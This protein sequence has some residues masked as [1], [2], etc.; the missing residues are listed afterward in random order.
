MI[1]I[2]TTRKPTQ[3]IR[4][5]IKELARVIPGSIRLTRGKQGFA[6]FCDAAYEQGATRLLLVGGFHGNPGRIGFLQYTGDAW[7]FFPPTIIIKSTQLLR[8]GQH[9]P[10]R[11][12]KKVVVLP[13][14]SFDLNKAK[15][16]AEA[17]KV[18]CIQRA[19]LPNLQ[20]NT[21]VLR[22][23]I[24]RYKA[25]DFVSPNETQLLGPSMKIKHFLTRPMG[26]EKR[27]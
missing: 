21:A 23:G 4:S 8:E 12:I 3:R 27:W 11:N 5:F 24:A 7:E 19:A 14:V 22:V 20:D 15:L 6:D 13:D 26:E 18:P 16:L 2:G 17:L 9:N 1:A 25:I 10:P